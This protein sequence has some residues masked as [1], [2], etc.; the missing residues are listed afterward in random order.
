MRVQNLV[1]L[2]TNRKTGKIYIGAHM[3]SG[4]TCRAWQE[5]EC[6]YLGSGDQIVEAIKAD[7][8]HNFRRETLGEFETPQEMYHFEREMVNRAFVEREDT[9]NMK[10]GGL[11]GDSSFL[12]DHYNEKA[13]LSKIREKFIRREAKEF[14]RL[15]NHLHR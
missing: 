6:T 11:G 13:T 4:E 5:G 2:T 8:I 1:Y 14:I 12:T 7:G 10:T 15:R 9:Y 3:C